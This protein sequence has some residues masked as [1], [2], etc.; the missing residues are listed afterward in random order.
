MKKWLGN[1]LGNEESQHSILMIVG[2]KDEIADS[3]DVWDYE[4]TI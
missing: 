3:I 4:I 1:D 2:L